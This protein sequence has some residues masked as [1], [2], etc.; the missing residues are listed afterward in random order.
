MSLDNDDAADA[1]AL[2]LRVFNLIPQVVEDDQKRGLR[3]KKAKKIA[4][5]IKQIK[6]RFGKQSHQNREARTPSPCNDTQ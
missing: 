3:N 5:R 1:L 6:Q 4:S 2:W